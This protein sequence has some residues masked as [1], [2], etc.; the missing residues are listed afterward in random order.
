MY[1]VYLFSFISLLWINAHALLPQG[2]SY[3]KKLYESPTFI[4]TLQ[5][6]APKELELEVVDPDDDTFKFCSQESRSAFLFKVSIKDE[7][8]D[9]HEMYFVTGTGS[10]KEGEFTNCVIQN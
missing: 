4:R 6:L 1:K 7:R 8:G 10:L 9:S 5:T 3:T 2:V